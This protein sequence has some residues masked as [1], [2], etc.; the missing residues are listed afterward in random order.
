MIIKSDKLVKNPII[1]VVV[2]TYN[3][4]L[5][6]KE[7]LDNILSQEISVPYEIILAEDCSQDS[8]REIC[9]EYQRQHSDVIL[10]LLQESNQGMMRNFRDVLRLVRGQFVAI[11]SGDDYWCDKTKLQ[12]QYDFLMSHPD[13]GVVHTKGYVLANGKLIETDGGHIAVDGDAREIAIYGAIGFASSICFRSK[14]LEYYHMDELIERGITMEDYPM[15]A[16]FAFYTKFFTL[17]DRMMVYRTVAGSVGSPPTLYKRA[18]YQLGW[19]KAGR[20]LKDLF[21]KD[22]P[23]T[24]E[25]LEDAINYQYFKMYLWAGDYE[26]ASALEFKTQEYSQRKLVRMKNCRIALSLVRLYYKY[27]KLQML[28]DE[29]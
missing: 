20:Y 15:N 7:C 28:T 25:E 18:Q 1:S 27:I 5:Y 19:W 11:C 21:P 6:L 12:K 23:W 10:L 8:T 29:R 4:E 24:D 14:L 16:I 2:T 13:Y 9:R 17:N 22:T 26:K 3:H